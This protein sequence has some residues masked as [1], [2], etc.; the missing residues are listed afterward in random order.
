MQNQEANESKTYKGAVKFDQLANY[1][2]KEWGHEEWIVNNAKYCGKKLVFKASYQLSM[3][4]HKIKEETFYIIAG[5]VFLETE[6]DGV[7]QTRLME[8]GD[9]AHI[10]PN[11]W[12]RITALVDSEVIEFSTHH[13][14]EDSYRRTHSCKVDLKALNLDLYLNE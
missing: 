9:I 4:H 3:H 7:R 11:M 2:E 10:K 5:K 12:H 8:P 6:H 1:V 14:D 13:M